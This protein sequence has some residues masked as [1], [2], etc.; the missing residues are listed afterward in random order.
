MK[1]RTEIMANMWLSFHYAHVFF[2]LKTARSILTMVSD[3]LSSSSRPDN[4]V[5]LK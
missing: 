2:L 1:Y 4:R 5:Q 3:E